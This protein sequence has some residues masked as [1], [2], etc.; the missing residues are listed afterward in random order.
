[1]QETSARPRA[2]RVG[3]DPGQARLVASAA[4]QLLDDRAGQLS[5]QDLQVA[6]DQAGFGLGHAVFSRPA[7][8]RAE[9]T[10]AEKSRQ[11]SRRPDSARTPAGVSWYSRRRRPPTTDQVPAISP[12]CSSRR[13]AG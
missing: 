9:V 13:S 2:T 7:F 10:M 4:A 11:A 6:A 8:S 5:R 12:A 3:N 1:M